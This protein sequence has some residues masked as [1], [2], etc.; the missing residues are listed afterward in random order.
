MT[1][2]VAAVVKMALS[3]IPGVPPMVISII[4]AIIGVSTPEQAYGKINELI[5]KSP[6]VGEK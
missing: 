1:K 4:D 3:L 6:A 5:A 2:E